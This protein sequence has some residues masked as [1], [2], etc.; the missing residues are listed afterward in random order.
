MLFIRL[1]GCNVG[2]PYSK[3]PFTIFSQDQP[4]LESGE[5][6]I[7]TSWDGTQFLCDTDYRKVQELSMDSI[8]DLI[9]ASNVHHV[10]ITGGEP[11]IHN[12]RPLISAV[13][14][15]EHQLHVETSGTR[16]IPEVLRNYL[17][18]T[19]SPKQGFLEENRGVIHEWKFLVGPDFD[20]LAAAK[21]IGSYSS[22][23]YLQP[24][25]SVDEVNAEGV[26]RCMK[27][28]KE[29]PAW[30]LSAQLH[31]YLGMP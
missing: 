13:C 10:C 27:I 2:K 12:L 4:K 24:I 19:C 25:G 23:V 28:L 31:K 30:R 17:W 16:P 26:A 5:N 6:T 11:F 20:P 8:M 29:Y 9:R 1:A 15:G 18:I 14:K 7:C 3:G 21:L 22:A